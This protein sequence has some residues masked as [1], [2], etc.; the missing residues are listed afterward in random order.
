MEVIQASTEVSNTTSKTTTSVA[1]LSDDDVS[2]DIADILA[3]ILQTD[4]SFNP[5]FASNT[6]ENL[7]N[8]GAILN[9]NLKILVWILTEFYN[10]KLS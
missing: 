6:T 9:Q 1:M 10:E 5:S 4:S 2:E 8:A 7:E 3:A